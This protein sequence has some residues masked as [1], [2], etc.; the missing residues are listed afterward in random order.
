MI[1]NRLKAAT[2]TTLQELGFNHGLLFLSGD[3]DEGDGPVVTVGFAPDE[4]DH[5][6]WRSLASSV[7][8]EET[9]LYPLESAPDAF[10]P[11]FAIPLWL[12]E[13]YAGVLLA[14]NG[15]GAPELSS[16]QVGDACEGLALVAYNRYLKQ[17]AERRLRQL[18]LI[19][20]VNQRITSAIGS[21]SKLET[22]VQIVRDTFDFYHTSILLV[23]PQT[24][25]LQVRVV[26]GEAA[27]EIVFDDLSFL[28][29]GKGLTS[30]V[31]EHGEPVLVNDV[32]RE[33]RYHG[34]AVLPDTRS[35]M[36]VPIR[37]GEKTIG[38]LDVQSD[39]RGAFDFVDLL[40]LQIV[41]NQV[42]DALENSRLLQQERTRRRMIQTLQETARVISSSL[43]LERVLDLIL[44]ELGR[45]VS[46]DNV[47]LKRIDN[48]LA[49]VI[50]ARG[51]PD[52]ERVMGTTYV[53]SENTL[54]SLIVYERQTVNIADITTDPR[55][56][57]LPGT[58][59]IR[60]WIGVP[61]LMKDRV[62][63]LLS[64]SRVE[65]RPFTEDETEMVSSFANHAAIAIENAR[66]YN[67]LKEFSATLEERVR[68]RTRE[69]EEAQQELAAVLSREVEV[70]EMERIR[71]ANELHDSV[72]QALIAANFQLQSV[73]MGLDGAEDSYQTTVGQLS[74]VQQMLDK[75]VSEIKA[76][77]HDLRPPALESLGLVLAIRQLAARYHDPPRFAVRTEVV[78]SVR[79]LS[80]STERTIYRV[81]QE[82]LSNARVHSEGTQFKLNLLFE[83]KRLKVIMQD[84]GAG[85]DPRSQEGKGLGLLTMHDRARSSGGTLSLKSAPGEGTRIEMELPIKAEEAAPAP[86]CKEGQDAHTGHDR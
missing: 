16:E 70:Q 19:A 74:Q 77:V 69:L 30:W 31:V 67:E 65:L 26:A 49:R 76:V 24:Q 46:Y 47:R 22:V 71:I 72:I 83:A 9:V 63:G 73:K 45:V 39:R 7:P 12:E 52:L 55:W 1:R 75:L 6:V 10:H 14:L 17:Q 42:A 85:F 13:Q 35:E 40:A 60:S 37:A 61:L 41:A 34:L 59:K 5:T 62:I 2:R 53:V 68:K 80:H 4:L 54:A 48:D 18:Q 25:A 44:R 81:I 56:L 23:D 84:D 43:E 82:G 3:E 78:G 15:Q 29:E 58:R 21:D 57:W 50:A 20:Q 28:Q 38:V 66:L 11:A 27:A 36:V 79:P 64:V 8:Q 32:T 33:E 86:P 51:F